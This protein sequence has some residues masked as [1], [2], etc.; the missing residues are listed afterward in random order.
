MN[1]FVDFNEKNSA[2]LESLVQSGL[3]RKLATSVVKNSL[4]E[5]GNTLEE[6]NIGGIVKGCNA[7]VDKNN[8]EIIFKSPVAGEH[9]VGIDKCSCGLTADQYDFFHKCL[10]ILLQAWLSHNR[11]KITSEYLTQISDKFSG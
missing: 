1:P 4:W 5:E 7:F 6:G 9:T 10:S 2:A 3:P 8:E 11:F